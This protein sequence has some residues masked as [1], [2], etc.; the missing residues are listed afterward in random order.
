LTIG[1]WYTFEVRRQKCKAESEIR[2]RFAWPVANLFLALNGHNDG[3]FP[4]MG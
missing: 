1:L 2:C 4:V 3:G